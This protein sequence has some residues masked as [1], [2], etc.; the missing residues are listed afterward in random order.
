LGA[1]RQGEVEILSGLKADDLVV[2]HGA[3]KVG[4][5]SQIKILAEEKDN[6]TLSELLQKSALEKLSVDRKESGSKLIEADDNLASEGTQVTQ[7]TTP[8]SN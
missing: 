6:E 7:V 5:G 3:I 8:V 1:R 4:D 2:T